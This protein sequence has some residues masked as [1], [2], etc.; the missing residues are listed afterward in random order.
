MS[1][2]PREKLAALAERGFG[3]DVDGRVFCKSCGRDAVWLTSA[4]AGGVAVAGCPSVPPCRRPN[5]VALV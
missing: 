5:S 1:D 3:V 4:P 2:A